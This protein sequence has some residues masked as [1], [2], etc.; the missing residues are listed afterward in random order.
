MTWWGNPGL[1]E[2][3]S[4]LLRWLSPLFVALSMKSYSQGERKKSIFTRKVWQVVGLHVA[5]NSSCSNS[6]CSEE[7]RLLCSESAGAATVRVLS[8]FGECI[9]YHPGLTHCFETILCLCGVS[10]CP[11][12]GS[13]TRIGCP[14]A[15]LVCTVCLCGWCSRGSLLWGSQRWAKSLRATKREFRFQCLSLSHTHTQCVCVSA[16]MFVRACVCVDSL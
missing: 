16:C 5:C 12:C 8:L 14:V 1:G 4:P 11:D 13:H 3:P 9:E 6:P 2:F 10:P 15:L 7:R